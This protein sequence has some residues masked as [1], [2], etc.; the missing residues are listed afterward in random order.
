MTPVQKYRV[1]IFIVLTGSLY[2]LLTECW[3][4][5]GNAYKD[6]TALSEKSSKIISPE[7]ASKKKRE[8]HSEVVALHAS[9]LRNSKGLDQ[10][11]SGLVE[12]VGESAK[13]EVIRIETLT[14]AKLEGG[15]ALSVSLDILGSFHRI[16][17]FLNTLENS[18]I[19]M[20]LEK[21]EITRGTGRILHVKMALKATFL[22]L[23]EKK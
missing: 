15:G 20:K 17:A 23:S 12:F 4:R 8:L 9:L 2:I 13:K 5:W 6:W 21:L 19:A 10:S 7:E 14:P 22:K 1:Y 3:E 16:A 11:E 18:P